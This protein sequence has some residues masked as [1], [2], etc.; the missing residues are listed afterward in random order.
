MCINNISSYIP[1]KIINTFTSFQNLEE[2]K[3]RVLVCKIIY[4]R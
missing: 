4:Y 3:E 1:Y 2:I